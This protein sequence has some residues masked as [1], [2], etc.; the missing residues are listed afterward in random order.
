MVWAS[1][2][3]PFYSIDGVR[4]GESV[5]VASVKLH[6]GAPLHIGLNYWYLA[7]QKHA[8]V[9]LKVRGG[10]VD[11]LGIATNLL[12]ATAHDQNVLMHSFY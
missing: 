3:N 6:T 5:A 1:T 12:T 4:A 7:V 9:V 2:S 11:E 10:V 8:T